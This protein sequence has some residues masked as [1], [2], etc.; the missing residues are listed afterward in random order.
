MNSR[1]IQFLKE[2]VLILDGAMGTMLQRYKFSEEDFRGAIFMDFPHSLKGNNDLL[3]LTQPNAVKNIHRQYLEAGADIIETNTFSSTT[4]GMSDYHLEEYVYRINF[5]S[6]RLAREAADEYSALTPNKPRFVAGSMGPTNRTAGISPDVNDP[7]FRAITFDELKDAYRL[8]ADALLDGGVDI[9]LVETVFDTLNAKAALFAIE[10]AKRSRKEGGLVGADV[11]VMLSGTVT[12]A[13][14]RTLSGQTVEAFLISVSHIPLLSIGLNCAFGPDQLKQYVRRLAEATSLNISAHP[15][16]GLPNEF[17]EYDQSAKIM[18]NHIK[19]Y[20]EEG[21]LNIVGG[22]CGTTPEHIKALSE[23]VKYYKPR[24]AKESAKTLKLSGLEPLIITPYTNFVNVGERTNVAG[25]K[26]FLNLIKEE[27]YCEAVEIARAQV[28]GGAQIIDVNMDDAMIDGVRAMTGFLNMIAAEPDIARVPVMVDSSRWKIIEAALKV[29]QGKGVV[30]SISLKEGE[31]AF[32]ERASKIRQYGAAVIVMAFDEVGQAD[33][34][35]RRIDICKRSYDILVNVVGFPAED[36]IFDPNIFPVAT[37][38]EEH[39]KNGVDFFA[40][41]KWIKE[42][43]PFAGVSGGVSNVSFSFRGNNR[44]REAMHSSFLYH[45]IKNGMTMGIVNPEMLEVYDEIDKELLEYVEDVLLDRRDDATER[46]VTFAE[47]LRDNGKKSEKPV[48]EWRGGALQERITHALVKGVEEYIDSD[49]EEAREKEA[50]PVEVIE[51]YLMNGMN[52][53]GDL[54][55]S[56]KMFLPQVVKSARVMKRAVAT[57][58]PYITAQKLSGVSKSG[59]SSSGKIV[60]ATVKGDIHDIGKN[61]VSVVLSCNNYEII[62]LGVMV[63][64]DTIIDTAVRER[65]DIIGLSGLITPSLEEMTGVVKELERR[66]LRIPVLIGGATTSKIHTAVKIAPEYSGVVVHV[67][68]ASRAVPVVRNLLGSNS[69]CFAATVKEEYRI[70]LEGHLQRARDKE[71]ISLEMARENKFKAN[72]NLF[73]PHSPKKAGIQVVNV[74]VDELIPYIDWTPFFRLWNLNGRYPAILND[75]KWGEEAT[76]L[77]RDAQ[78]LLEVVSERTGTNGNLNAPTG[79]CGV[80]KAN[81]SGDDIEVYNNSNNLGDNE[82]VAHLIT[83]RQQ[84]AVKEGV[85]NY[86]LADFIA[87]KD[88]GR[89]DYIGLFCVTAGDGI[90]KIAQEYAVA[91]DDYSSIIVK[92]L[93]DR[94]AEAFAEYLHEKV[95]KEIWGYAADENLSK[96]DLIAVN[97]SGIRPAPGYPACPDHLEK[98]TIWKLLGVEKAIGVKLTENM[99]M[100]PASSVSGYYFSHP[101][102]KYFGLGKIGRD[103]LADYASR[104]GISIVEAEKWLFSHIM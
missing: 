66:G 78:K 8:Q 67:S 70:L 26:K 30:N 80:F 4:V 83:L 23:L 102:S 98:E 22:C 76:V 55:G 71:I 85:S 90:E 97:Y 6:A 87:P 36:I 28:E 75:E 82:I 17:G 31:A 11:P 19:G 21:L 64:A 5:E 54:F 50:N 73:C 103:Q 29:I 16:A 46:L 53:V 89:E 61:I 91:G 59:S 69:S 95:R 84:K 63:S 44:V 81:S 9:L 65:A 3:S 92:A 52:V 35:M 68:D 101:E 2:K 48:L 27:N 93:G 104:R 15:N 32:V 10:E 12:D 57:L 60:M 74:P 96:A 86:A 49:V 1:L 42:N 51:K 24:V 72:W 100:Y 99:A 39:R 7:G 56:G 77:F 37:G 94:L 14:G 20:L 88:C 40:A 18:A 58:L 25:S 45:A 34:F 62:D 43:L 13:S 33:S 38:M 79:V 41:T 47:T